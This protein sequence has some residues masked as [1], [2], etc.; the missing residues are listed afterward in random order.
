MNNESLFF[1]TNHIVA[2]DL[3]SSYPPRNGKVVKDLVDSTNLFLIYVTKQS[4]QSLN[5]STQ[6]S[7]QTFHQ[8][9]GI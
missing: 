1:N 6:D 9:D 8:P 7:N 3:I 5:I 2:G 4:T